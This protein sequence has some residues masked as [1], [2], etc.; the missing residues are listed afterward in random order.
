MEKCLG[1]SVTFQTEDEGN[2]NKKMGSKDS[3]YVRQNS[4]NE[5]RGTV[6]APPSRA[7]DKC[8]RNGGKSIILFQRS[9]SVL[10]SL[11]PPYYRLQSAFNS[12]TVKCV[13]ICSLILNLLLLFGMCVVGV[14]FGMNY[15]KEDNPKHTEADFLGRGS[16]IGCY[17]CG[18]RGIPSVD[19]LFRATNGYCCVDQ[20]REDFQ[21]VAISKMFPNDTV[22]AVAA[23]FGM[24]R[25][26]QLD[27]AKSNGSNRKQPA[28]YRVM[29]AAK[30]ILDTTKSKESPTLKW[31]SRA[32][33][34]YVMG[35][36]DFSNNKLCL[37]TGGLV[38]LHSHFGLD[39]VNNELNN[40]EEQFL[41]HSIYKQSGKQ[42]SSV[43]IEK[44][45]M[46]Q[47]TYRSADLETSE[48]LRPGDCV[49]VYFS[50]PSLIY[51]LP[52]SNYFEIIVLD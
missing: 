11:R 22:A 41:T 33:G 34:A 43:A 6:Y 8:G 21:K 16:Q 23:R 50:H 32:S 27:C 30:L 18:E 20:T 46:K 3:V 12:R 49:Y 42:I 2:N 52:I 48:R 38:N 13:F 25:A 7:D 31:Q 40:G 24:S 45:A 29:T 1:H 9:S 36:V 4:M 14:F 17:P 26:K 5:E 28:E 15:K 37:K 39:T 51:N 44:L 47:H 35:A 10:E 19:V